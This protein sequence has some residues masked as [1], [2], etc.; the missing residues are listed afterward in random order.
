MTTKQAKLRRNARTGTRHKPATRITIQGQPT[1]GIDA[2]HQ[3]PMPMVQNTGS[4][5]TTTP[6]RGSESPLGDKLL[7]N[8][9]K[10]TDW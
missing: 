6:P 7:Q 4:P 10:T 8:R 5:H 1:H 3:L 9:E 2:I